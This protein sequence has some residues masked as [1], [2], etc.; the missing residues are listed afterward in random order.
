MDHET[1][2]NA[3]AIEH[4]K[5]GRPERNLYHLA[6]KISR[7][8]CSNRNFMYQASQ[9]NSTDHVFMSLLK[10]FQSQMSNKLAFTTASSTGTGRRSL[11]VALVSPVHPRSIQIAIS[12]GRA[13]S[14][15]SPARVHH[16]AALSSVDILVEVTLYVRAFD[17][18]SSANLITCR[19]HSSVRIWIL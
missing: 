3:F 14:S 17:A 13:P 6:P 10:V 18:I 15:H 4:Q 7:I 19:G 9:I 5:I 16:P 12:S 1:V 11:A 8:F 2:T